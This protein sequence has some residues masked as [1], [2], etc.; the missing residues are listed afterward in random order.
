MIKKYIKKAI[1]LSFALTVAVNTSAQIKDV[2]FPYG[3]FK[4]VDFENPYINSIF[5]KFIS[6]IQNKDIKY[7]KKIEQYN[8]D[9]LETITKA[10]KRNKYKK[11]DAQAKIVYLINYK[12]E[13][14]I[15][16]IRSSFYIEELNAFNSFI[17]SIK[18]SSK[19][20]AKEKGIMLEAIK[21]LHKSY[22]NFTK[23]YKGIALYSDKLCFSS[24]KGLDYAPL[25]EYTNEYCG[26]L[27][28]KFNQDFALSLK[29]FTVFG[30]NSLISKYLGNINQGNFNKSL[31]MKIDAIMR[32]KK[33]K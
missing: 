12:E 7:N 26:G 33:I 3:E 31:Q 32:N 27:Y 4:E 29:S 5:E 22:S 13:E 23:K 25:Y 24:P 16:D 2:T 11:P 21:P 30:V 17:K 20:T 19:I 14:N 9:Y 28:N 8:H 15:K 18:A 6:D 1:L 10:E